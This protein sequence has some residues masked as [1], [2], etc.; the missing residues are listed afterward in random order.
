MKQTSFLEDSCVPRQSLQ[1][2]P[3]RPRQLWQQRRHRPVP[4]FTHPATSLFRSWW[5][6][7]SRRRQRRLF[8]LSYWRA[9]PRLSLVLVVV[10]WAQLSMVASVV[11]HKPRWSSVRCCCPLCRHGLLLHLC[12]YATAASH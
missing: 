6:L 2:G 7:S 1:L 12:L 8:A 4:R 10:H 11:A 5:Q 3:H 9:L